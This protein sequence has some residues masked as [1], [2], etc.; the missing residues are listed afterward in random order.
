MNHS[1]EPAGQRGPDWSVGKEH[2]KLQSSF[3]FGENGCE[4]T[5]LCETCF[6]V[7]CLPAV[8]QW[9]RER[10]FHVLSQPAPVDCKQEYPVESLEPN[11]AL[12]ELALQWNCYGQHYN[13]RTE[14]VVADI[15]GPEKRAGELRYWDLTMEH[16]KQRPYRDEPPVLELFPKNFS[17]FS[18]YV[19][20]EK[21]RVYLHYLGEDAK[22][23]R[24]PLKRAPDG[25]VRGHLTSSFR[26]LLVVDDGPKPYFIKLNGDS[27]EARSKGGKLSHEKKIYTVAVQKAVTMGRELKVG[28]HLVADSHGLLASHE[29]VFANWNS[30]YRD[31][32]L[33]AGEFGS[34]WT[35][36]DTLIPVH[37]LASQK[38]FETEEGTRV[39][40]ATSQER[41]RWVNREFVPP[42]VDI[43]VESGFRQGVHLEL[44]GQ[45]IDVLLSEEG[46]VRQ[47][48][49]KDLGDVGVDPVVR[50]LMGKPDLDF[51]PVPFN[52]V[53]LATS[54]GERLKAPT[55]EVRDWYRL[56]VGPM[57]FTR[58]YFGN[59]HV[60]H[61][62]QGVWEQLQSVVP[63][64][65]GT[66]Q[67]EFSEL[68]KL[69][70]ANWED[71][72]I[73]RKAGTIGKIR[74][75]YI[76]SLLAERLNGCKAL[77]VEEVVENMIAATR[78][79][80]V[81]TSTRDDE[82]DRGGYIA[83]V[84]NASLLLEGRSWKA[85]ELNGRQLLYAGKGRAIEHYAIMFRP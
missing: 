35:K 28:D 5:S 70:E 51:S 40:G 49:V 6:S 67:P 81:V 50:W 56:L 63:R 52:I 48:F 26:T 41:N 82:P 59:G 20:E 53:Q 79:N 8:L 58:R 66:L 11:A 57:G 77:P 21:T 38:F 55:A 47:V 37:A 24:V 44:H 72:E 74:E 18:P 15:Y 2:G 13:T 19:Q 69:S 16:L 10:S 14:L 29:R 34:V 23:R 46:C 7:W 39:L 27:I 64:E 85:C 42:L 32:H 80:L 17:G 62:V 3:E 36:S 4:E 71:L 33:S 65:F 1:S 76:K 68:R 12:R 22:D 54:K 84:T 73:V 75:W 45:N 43:I 31:F 30:L 60:P 61:I 83:Y 25:T 78:E 9:V